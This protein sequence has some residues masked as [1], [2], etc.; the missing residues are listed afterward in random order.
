MVRLENND[1]GDVTP[2]HDSIV[3]FW[4]GPKEELEDVELHEHPQPQRVTGSEVDVVILLS[5]AD[6]GP[7]HY[8]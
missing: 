4:E 6:T 1:R 2:D 5:A 3:T 7:L 8:G